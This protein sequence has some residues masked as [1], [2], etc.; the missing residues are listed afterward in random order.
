MVW[1]FVVFGL[2]FVSE[3]YRRIG[4]RRSLFEENFCVSVRFRR[5][6]VILDLYVVNVEKMAVLR[7]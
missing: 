7:K 3:M 1:L 5:S 4:K 6:N 2:S